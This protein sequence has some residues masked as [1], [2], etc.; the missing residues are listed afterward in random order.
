MFRWYAFI[1]L[2]SA[3]C[4][5][6]HAQQV[7]P[8]KNSA[9]PIEQRVQDLLSRMTPE[10]KFWQCFM[11]P[12][13]LDN[14]TP[15]QYK[16]GL[17]GFQVSAANKGEGA[18]Q[19]M[20]QYNT[21]ETAA[22]LVAKVNAIQKYFVEQTRLGIPIIVFDETLHGLVRKGATAFP[23]AIGLAASFDSSLMY[24]V[25]A[26]IA[27][28]TKQ[29][30]IRQ[31]LS[32]VINIASDVRWGRTEETYGEDPMLASAM[33]VAYIRAFEQ[34]GIITTPKH[35]LANV[36]DGGRDSYPIHFNERLLKEI[37]LP[38]FKAAIQQAGAGSVMTSYNSI[39]GSPAT[40]S[41]WLLQDL[42]KKEYG[43][44]GFVIS[45]ASA[46]GGANVLHY[47]ASD[48]AD[49][50]KRAMQNGLDVIFQT[51]YDHYKLF[52]PPFLNDSIS[53]ARIDDAVARILTAKFTLG[54][55]EQPYVSVQVN[56]DAQ[57]KKH[58]ALAEEA[59]AK[60]F[61]LLQNNKQLLPLSK[62]LKS[63][64]VFG[65]EAVAARLG[66]Y[67]GPGNEVVSILQGLQQAVGKNTTIRYATGAG[68][69]SN[70][71]QVVSQKY[72]FTD[73]SLKQPGLQ[74]AYFKNITATGNADATRIDPKI[75]FHWT[76]YGPDNL[77]VNQFYS[78]QWKGFLQ[79][80]VS[81]KYQ[82]GLEGNDGYRLYINGK[83]L[84]DRWQK[85]TYQQQT[86]SFLFEKNKAYEI[87]V[88]FYEPLGNA[89]IK[90]IWNIEASNAQQQIQEAVALA[91]QSDVCIVVAG[92]TEGEFQD[93]AMLSLPGHQEALIKAVAATGKPLVVL[94][95]AGS[96]VVMTQWMHDVQSIV[97]V[98]YPGEAGG[99][100]VA[101]MLFGKTNPAG[102][103]PI[104]VPLHEAQLPLVYN[105]KPT[106]RGDDYNNLSGQ[107]LFPFGY[108]LSYTQF[109]YS[110]MQV[111]AY[112]DY[113]DTVAVIRC[114]IQNTG[115]AD[116]DEVVQLYVHDELASIARPVMEL[117]NFTRIS[118]KK[119]ESKTIEMALTR[120]D[121]KLYDENLQWIFEPGIFRIMLGSS[122]RDIRLQQLL[123]IDK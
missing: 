35:F 87:R 89:H 54:L 28:E 121:L 33:A 45:D 109:S 116:G 38:P 104:S 3:S 44:K 97:Q 1:F 115:S 82:I 106:G 95:T 73:A 61:V 66:G 80:P 79:S 52:I 4:F 55:F 25:A 93:R 68:R 118:L 100:A 43:F 111:Q 110:N 19:Q 42:L 56:D 72:L 108:G 47:T 81:G 18:S 112:P 91:K 119:G 31:V 62:Q 46:V 6:A 88:D 98:W 53:N 113:S 12:G 84:I 83:L 123:T 70:E 58:R 11:I 30:G 86:V 32:P 24:K 76:L 67:S 71:W 48:Y 85:Q 90:L 75:D 65:E 99:H 50:S 13:D 101:D 120:E 2:L 7:L 15:G 57:Q 69:N 94:L 117:K 14:A 51:Q 107:P 103:L 22:A 39:D 78:V 17:F 27:A 40:A 114:S 36:G 105:H 77:Q 9:L 20:L 60:S 41:K 37:H 10:E 102:R 26:A 122:S 64:A 74:A 49:A 92:I 63:I 16:N 21:G 29:R 8:Y 96:A 23:Q 59:A 5:F 34:A